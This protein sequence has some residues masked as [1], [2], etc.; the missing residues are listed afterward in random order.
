MVALCPP[1]INVF[2]FSAD[3]VFFFL[4]YEIDKAKDVPNQILIYNNLNCKNNT[5]FLSMVNHLW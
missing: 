3:A 4:P 2:C 1:F 5:V